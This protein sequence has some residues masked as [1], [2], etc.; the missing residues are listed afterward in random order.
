MTLRTDVQGLLNSRGEIVRVKLYTISGATTGYDDD[1]VLSQSGNSVFTSGLVQPIGKG[2]TEALL[3][4]QGK[5]TPNDYKLFLDASVDISGQKVIFDIGSPN[6]ISYSIAEAGA[7]TWRDE[8][9]DIYHKIFIKRLT[10]GS[11]YQGTP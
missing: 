4:Q 6:Y 7:Q 2:S 9:T 10:T 8:A 11:F 1:V 5:L 3:L